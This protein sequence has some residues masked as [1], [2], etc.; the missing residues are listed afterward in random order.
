MRLEDVVYFSPEFKFSD[1][2][3]TNEEFLIR[4][5]RD[6]IEGYYLKAAEDALAHDHFF[7][8]G[9]LCCSVIDLLA[10]KVSGLPP[11]L[12]VHQNIERFKTDKK[13]AID[14][15]ICFRHGLSHEGRVKNLK[16]SVRSGQFSCDFDQFVVAEDNMIVVNPRLLLQE[17]RSAFDRFCSS[18]QKSSLVALLR[19][20]FQPEAISITSSRVKRE[21]KE[22]VASHGV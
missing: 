12:W 21:A 3:F 4:A 8:C 2:D 17:T 5:F 9:L 22:K 7:A 19:R 11:G 20:Y 6:R 15:W 16:K 10:D 14:F 13:L 1:L 18:D